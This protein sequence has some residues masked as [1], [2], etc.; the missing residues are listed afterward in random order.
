MD[1]RISH[2]FTGLRGPERQ[3]WEDRE[4]YATFKALS[5]S[6]YPG[7]IQAPHERRKCLTC[8]IKAWELSDKDSAAHPFLANALTHSTEPVHSS[9][10]KMGFF[11][12]KPVGES[13]AASAVQRSSED[14]KDA[15]DAEKDAAFVPELNRD[16][17]A[18]VADTAREQDEGVTKIEALCASAVHCYPDL[19]DATRRPCLWKRMEVVD[20]LD[21]SPLF[22]FA[23]VH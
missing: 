2:E 22:L 4:G 21:V 7:L 1:V 20:A 19:A 6:V 18:A 14:S 12:R 17:E 13:P 15:S 3:L 10:S 11:S 5:C 16:K 23:G 9:R 8:E